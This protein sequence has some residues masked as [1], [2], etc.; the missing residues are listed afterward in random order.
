MIR[1]FSDL[2]KEQRRD[3][4]EMACSMGPE[5]PFSDQGAM[6]AKYGSEYYDGGDS[7]FTLCDGARIRGALGV[8]TREIPGR[9]E[10]F[11]SGVYVPRGNEG[12]LGLL[13]ARVL[14]HLLPLTVRELKLGISGAHEHLH[15]PLEELGF[16]EA[17]TTIELLHQSSTVLPAPNPAFCMLPLEEGNADEYRRVHNAAFARSPNGAS[18]SHAGVRK[19][20]RPDII[21]GLYVTGGEAVGVY[22]IRI[23]GDTGWIVGLAVHPDHQGRGLGGDLLV[24]LVRKLYGAGCT[25]VRLNVVSSNERALG[26]YTARGFDQGRVLSRWFRVGVDSAAP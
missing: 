26:L 22:D 23:D 10:A 19:L 9:G 11:I 5:P 21:A 8:I 3:L 25:E 20:M 1:R 15:G 12:V 6:S 13:V 24:R 4:F 7:Y 2:T 14:L 18:L 17:Y 16:E